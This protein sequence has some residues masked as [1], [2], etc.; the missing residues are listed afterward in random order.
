MC[1][2]GDVSGRLI[3]VADQ[4]RLQRGSRRLWTAQRHVS[5]DVAVNR[6]G[7]QWHGSSRQGAGGFHR[8]SS[9]R[10]GGRW[11]GSAVLPG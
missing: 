6:A 3:V 10:K 11:T 4:R 2:H 8:P 7:Q 9:Q 1:A 5:D